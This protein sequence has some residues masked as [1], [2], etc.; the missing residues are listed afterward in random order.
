MSHCLVQ[1]LTNCATIKS[2]E[3]ESAEACEHTEV[4]GNPGT[5]SGIHA[6][7]HCAHDRTSG[8]GRICCAA[9]KEVTSLLVLSFLAHRAQCI[10]VLLECRHR[11]KPQGMIK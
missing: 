6:T 1:T 9:K 8:G 2:D 7:G 5:G 4:C 11:R 10:A 3:T